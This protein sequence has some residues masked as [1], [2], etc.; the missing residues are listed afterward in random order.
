MAKL[1]IEL[2]PVA[3]EQLEELAELLETTKTE[4]V[5]GAL[6]LYAHIVYTTLESPEKL[7]LGFVR[8]RD[9][10]LEEA[11]VV[12]K[13]SHHLYEK[14]AERRKKMSEMDF[15]ATGGTAAPFNTA[16]S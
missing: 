1:T 10:E 15:D 4:A 12:P 7:K 13:L 9:L 6:D 3:T 11:I 16:G 8:Q 5:R 14:Y 2:G